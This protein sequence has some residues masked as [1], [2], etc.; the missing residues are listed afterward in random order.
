MLYED[1]NVYI[2]T[3]PINV[4]QAAYDVLKVSLEPLFQ[5]YLSGSR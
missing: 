5:F 2:T 3:T 1:A 4:S